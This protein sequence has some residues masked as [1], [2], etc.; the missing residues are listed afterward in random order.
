M[1]VEPK[2]V[3][4]LTN[5]IVCFPCKAIDIGK[6]DVTEKGL[7]TKNSD[8]RSSGFRARKKCF[9]FRHWLTPVEV[10]EELWFQGPYRIWLSSPDWADIRACTASEL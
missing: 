2:E 4:A 9:P 5:E 1:N 3:P 8:L 10:R 7:G 6:N